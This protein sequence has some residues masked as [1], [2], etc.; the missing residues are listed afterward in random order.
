MPHDPSDRKSLE[1]RIPSTKSMLK[2]GKDL[3]VILVIPLALWGIRLEIRLAA[4]EA[5][6]ERLEQEVQEANDTLEQVDEAVQANCIQ[7]ARLE[8]KLDAAK[9]GIDDIKNIL[10]RR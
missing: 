1:G 6:N 8:T 4:L 9:D 2:W 5:D 3:L 7:L 10:D